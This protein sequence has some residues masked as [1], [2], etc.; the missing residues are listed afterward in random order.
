[1]KKKETKKVTKKKPKVKEAIPVEENK[2]EVV[3]EAQE[4]IDRR[5]LREA[6]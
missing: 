1:M 4:L 3:V 2:T 6:K 5:K